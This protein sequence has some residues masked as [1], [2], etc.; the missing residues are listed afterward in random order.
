MSD[1]EHNNIT[2]STAVE[3]AASIEGRVRE[4]RL[5]FGGRL[6]TVRGLAA[7]L[8]V[9]PSTVAAAYRSLRERGLVTA[10]GRGG[11]RIAERP[12]VRSRA[13]PTLPKGV[14]NLSHGNPDPE[15]LP[16][17]GPALRT[18]DPPVR[19]Y[20]EDMSLPELLE[21]A[22]EHL[23]AKR[24]PTARLAVV[25][26]ALDGIERVLNANLLRGDRV[27]VEDP[28]FSGV[29][30][31]LHAQG[32]VPVPVAID[33]SGLLPEAL[34]AVLASGVDALI[35]TPRAQNPT[36]AALTTARVRDLRAVL[37]RHP[38]VLVIE[39]D[40]AGPVAGVPAQTLCSRDRERWAVVASVSK[41]LGPDL[42]LAVLAGDAVTVGR[43]DGRQ[44]LG[45]RWVS[46][47]LQRLVVALWVQRG[48]Q[49]K[50]AHAAR[51]YTERRRFLID[52]LAEHGIRAHGRSG[53][54]VWVPVSEEAELVAAL[55]EAGSAV[56]AGERFRISS[57]PA[58]RITT[59]S[60][61]AP[62]AKRLAAALASFQRPTRTTPS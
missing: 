37:E 49:K 31:L 15:L 17:L 52:A 21:G 38:G 18:L 50:L 20:A 34:Q 26:G 9:S 16:P 7:D 55:M 54:N 25:A 48:M 22:R 47:V 40:H 14:L 44:L 39:D 51:I 2:G 59:A 8:E 6:P 28:A 3:I 24:V 53:L 41:S 4:S 58:L 11:T 13:S 42:R 45:I 61:R 35:L 56:S 12:P 60:L 43:V 33:D 1:S 10:R 19:L 5:E 29:L 32:M 30:D 36:G 27:A 23:F 62:Q 57:P 46:H